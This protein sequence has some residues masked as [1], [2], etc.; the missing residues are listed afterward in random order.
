MPVFD[1]ARNLIAVLDVDSTELAA[2]DLEDARGLEKICALFAR[3]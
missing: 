1:S 2:F 3:S